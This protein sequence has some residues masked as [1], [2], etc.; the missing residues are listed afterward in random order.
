MCGFFFFSQFAAYIFWSTTFYKNRFTC[1]GFKSSDLISLVTLYTLIKFENGFRNHDINQSVTKVKLV[2]Y[3]RKHY[4][5][6]YLKI[7]L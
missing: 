6:I 3:L 2:P 4:L 1:L 7:N 5:N